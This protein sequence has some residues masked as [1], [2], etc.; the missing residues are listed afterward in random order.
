[1]QN[2]NSLPKKNITLIVADFDDTI[3]ARKEQLE[4]DENLRKFR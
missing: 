2:Y 4:D 1:M 3:F